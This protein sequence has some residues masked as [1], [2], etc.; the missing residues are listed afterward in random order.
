MNANSVNMPLIPSV[1]NTCFV[2]ITYFPDEE[3]ITRLQR[4][5]QQ[6]KSII[7]VDNASGNECL[8]FLRSFSVSPSVELIENECNEGIAE[9]L[10]QGIRLATELGFSWV[11]TLDQDTRIHD[12]MFTVLSGIYKSSGCTS[13]LIGSNYWDVFRERAYLPDEFCNNREYVK[14]RTVITA[15][16]LLRLDLFKSIGDYR[17]DYFIDSVDHEYCLRARSHGFKV[18]SS[19]EP[20]MSQSIGRP[21]SSGKKIITFDHPRL[22][23]YYIARNSLVTAKNY[24]W[25]EP[26]WALRQVIG[27]SQS[28]LF[29]VLRESDK[30]SKLYAYMRGIIDAIRN[31]LGPCDWI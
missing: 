6:L 25:K 23:R 17:S 31:K 5:Q 11:L 7:I 12:N 16:T 15:G 27:L 14:Q 2:I 26:V 30:K 18:L 1:D 13:P 19:C 20:L 22:R 21:N 3:I 4:V 29:V 9:A 24:M 8:S 10:N 28:C